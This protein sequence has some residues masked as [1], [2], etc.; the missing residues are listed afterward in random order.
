M[1]PTALC[2]VS[3]QPPAQSG[4]SSPAPIAGTCC[5]CVCVKH[6]PYFSWPNV[7]QSGGASYKDQAVA[8]PEHVVT[9]W[10][11]WFIAG[12]MAGESCK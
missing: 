8:Q 3:T 10:V 6:L 9:H 7:I 1:P 12:G 2:S 11:D 5:Y 4:L